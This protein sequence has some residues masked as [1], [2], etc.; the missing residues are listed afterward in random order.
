MITRRK[1]ITGSAAV[2]IAATF[3]PDTFSALSS[4]KLGRIGFI[5]G[6][7]EKELKGDWK[8][9]LKETVK[10]GYTEIEI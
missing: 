1:F 2:A 3:A 8:V 9:V 10:Y 5:E 6:I 4:K 7:I